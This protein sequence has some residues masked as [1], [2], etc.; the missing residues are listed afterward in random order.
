MINSSL[1]TNR[2]RSLAW[3][4]LTLTHQKAAIDST[5]KQIFSCTARHLPMIPTELVQAVYWCNVIAWN[6]SYTLASLAFNVRPL[7]SLV[8]VKN[9]NLLSCDNIG[10]KI[11]VSITFARGN[12]KMTNLEC[13][14]LHKTPVAFKLKTVRRQ[15]RTPSFTGYRRDQESTVPF[16]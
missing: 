7:T 4:T 8:V 15:Y 16:Y 1:K 2:H 9:D 13:K 11:I 6:P 3:T 5:A 12:L 10:Y 14:N